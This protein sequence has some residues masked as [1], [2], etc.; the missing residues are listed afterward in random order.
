MENDKNSLGK[1]KDDISNIKKELYEILVPVS[2]N[3]GIKYTLEHHQQW[4]QFVIAL[5]NGLTIL[6]PAKGTRISPDNESFKESMIPVRIVCNDSQISEIADFT[7]AHYS[8]KAIMYCLISSN[9][10]IKN[11]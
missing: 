2:S 11:Y 1:G 9:V 5:A 8:Q 7:A 10:T 3:D 4:D 6:K